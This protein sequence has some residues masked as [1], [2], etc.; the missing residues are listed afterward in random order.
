MKHLQPQTSPTPSENLSRWPSYIVAVAGIL[1]SL[2][3]CY[4][5]ILQSDSQ[6]KR[7]IRL[8]TEHVTK[9]IRNQ[10]E[11]RISALKH[12]AK[13]LERLKIKD[14]TQ[15][16]ENVVAYINDYAGFEAIAWLDPDLHIRWLAPQGDTAVQALY[17]RFISEH[18]QTIKKIGLQI[19]VW[20]SPPI[21]ITRPDDRDFFVIVPLVTNNKEPQGYLASLISARDLFNIQLNATNYSVD[22]M[23]GN[24]KIFQYGSPISNPREPWISS[25]LFNIYGTVWKVDAKPSATFLD[26]LG[27]ALPWV[28]LLLGISVS[29]LFAVT[30]H[31]TQITKQ[32]AKSLDSMNQDLK[33][34][35]HERTLAEETKQKLEKALLQGQKL[36]AIGTLAGGIAHDFNNILYAII[37]FA[38]MSRDDV[39]RDSVIYK[40]LGRVLEASHRGRELISRILAFSRRQQHDFHTIQL[41]TTVESVLGLLKPTIPAGVTINFV[42]SLSDECSV[43]GNQTQ[44]HQV[45]INMI[46]NAVDA[47]DGEGTITIR[48]SHA[49]ASNP[50]LDQFPQ[51]A[52]KNY[53]KI[54][55]IDTGYGMDLNT[56]ERV[57]E[58]FFTTKEVGR[59]T[60]LGLATAHAIVQEHQGDITVESQLG[61]GATFTILLPEYSGMYKGEKHDEDFT[62]RG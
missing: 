60:G 29:I 3:W 58:P 4:F 36:Q 53:C 33:N 41:K 42:C 16:Q 20:I 24:Q 23:D 9:D 6:L 47:M 15:W 39:P 35:I 21:D 5:L 34:E 10:L 40:N 50:F 19:P 1:I 12:V 54:D 57:F 49:L 32:R 44:L 56:M 37:G 27:N 17:T 55:V 18:T 38:E 11:I 61:H 13:R 51:L 7:I 14:Y 25:T 43:L 45:L 59:G 62:S 46:N 48:L 31:L 26:S 28:T 22:I 52:K 30:I 8:Q 2:L